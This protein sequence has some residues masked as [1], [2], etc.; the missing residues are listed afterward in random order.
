[1]ADTHSTPETDRRFGDLEEPLADVVAWAGLL[2]KIVEHDV[3]R[4]PALSKKELIRLADELEHVNDELKEAVDRMDNIY[5]R[6]EEEAG[7]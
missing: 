3:S 4:Y 5:H 7:Q 1:M 2:D 6:R